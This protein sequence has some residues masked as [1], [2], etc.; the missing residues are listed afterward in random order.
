MSKISTRTR[1]S[2]VFGVLIALIGLA[3]PYF[4]I[5]IIGETGEHALVVF[6]IGGIYIIAT[7]TASVVAAIKR[8]IHVAFPIVATFLGLNGL[9]L[10][11][12]LFLLG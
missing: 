1:V 11:F 6:L 7:I 9:S 8:K 12:V 10:L 2:I 5:E 3:W 4:L